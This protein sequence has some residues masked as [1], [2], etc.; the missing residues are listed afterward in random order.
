MHHFVLGRILLLVMEHTINPYEKGIGKKVISIRGNSVFSD[1]VRKVSAEETE[2]EGIE[3]YSTIQFVS[4]TE[5][6]IVINGNSFPVKLSNQEH[7]VSMS[8]IISINFNS[9]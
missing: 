2:S 7:T 1:S 6:V 8:F 9:M 3:P 4:S 5:A